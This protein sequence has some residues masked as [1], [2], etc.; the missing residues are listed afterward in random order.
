MNASR[1]SLAVAPFAVAPFAVAI[2]LCLTS[3]A[4]LAQVSGADHAD[5]MA[6]EIALKRAQVRAETPCWAGR[7]ATPQ[8]LPA[9][10]RQGNYPTTG[11][12][13]KVP[14]GR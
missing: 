11:T 7:V 2:V 3:G 13:G 8:Q 9:R 12:A 5:R 6:A 14:C 1:L 10:T 4:A